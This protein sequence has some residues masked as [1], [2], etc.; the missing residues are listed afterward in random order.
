[1]D[2]LNERGEK[3][4][5]KKV[6]MKLFSRSIRNN[7][8]IFG[9]F[10]CESQGGKNLSPDLSWNPVSGAESYVILVF[11]PDAPSG[12][13]IHWLISHIPNKITNLPV[14]P[15]IN[16]KVLE[17]RDEKLIQGKNSWGNYGYGGPCPSPGK[18]HRYYFVVYALDKMVELG[19]NKVETFLNRIQSHVIGYGH[20]KGIYKRD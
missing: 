2:K 16:N 17:V 12:T 10:V 6:K 20:I 1:M 4:I 5:G 19:N 11:D 15:N 3:G 18:E 7:K 9:K 14:L 8:S 13:W